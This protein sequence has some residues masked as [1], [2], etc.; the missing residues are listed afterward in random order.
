MD[1]ALA[2][3]HTRKLGSSSLTE[4]FLKLIDKALVAAIARH[5]SEHIMAEQLPGVK[6]QEPLRSAIGILAAL[7]HAAPHRA[8]QLL[9]QFA[10]PALVTF[11]C[12]AVSHL[13]QAISLPL[14][15]LCIVQHTLRFNF[16]NLAC[17]PGNRTL[18]S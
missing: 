6:T 7:A 11:T 14:H 5:F 10:Q 8:Q 13:S 9:T 12:T 16:I 15:H 17:E 4:Q 18:Q 2:S 3:E 1:K